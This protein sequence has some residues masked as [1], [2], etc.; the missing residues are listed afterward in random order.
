MMAVLRLLMSLPLVETQFRVS[1]PEAALAVALGAAEEA[2][3]AAD[4]EVEEDM[5]EEVVGME[6]EVMVEV[7]GVVVVAGTEEAAGMAEAEAA[8]EGV[9]VVGSRGIW[10]EIVH[11]VVVVVEAAVEGMVVETVVEEVE[12]V[13]GVI[14]V[15]GLVILLG[16]VLIVDVDFSVRIG[17]SKRR[18]DLYHV[19]FY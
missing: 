17:N 5:E 10:L 3:A 14:I 11:K 6:V 12:E 15:V 19:F 8:V 16:T 4:M 13:E 1:D 18:C 7:G 9:I 2:A